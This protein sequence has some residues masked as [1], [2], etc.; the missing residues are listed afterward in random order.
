[1]SGLIMPL[2]Q[3]TVEP[4]AVSDLM[5]QCGISAYSDPVL[6]K[7]QNDRLSGLIVAARVAC[8]NY[9]KRAFVS[10]MFLLKLDSFSGY[11]LRYDC[12]QFPAID[13]TML[14]FQAIDT[15][16]YVDVAG[17]VQKL[18][19]DISYG[20]V[21][22]SDLYGYQ[23]ERGS[24]SVPARIL[25]VWARP[26]PPTR[27]V[28]GAVG[29][30]FRAGYGA[31]AT[32]SVGEGSDQLSV[33]GFSFLQADAPL[34]MGEIG[35]S[36]TIPGAG[37]NGSDLDTTV[38]AVTG[39]HS[40]TL[41]D[42]ASISVDGVQVWVGRHV[43]EPISMAIMFLA[44]FFYEQGGVVDQAPPRVVQTLLSPYLW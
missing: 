5:V 23:L 34:L 27:R 13:L 14:P 3:P 22:S 26:W 19:L 15:V 24:D 17:D 18:S 29:V 42:V 16:Y 37:A 35:L 7:Q 6:S 44:Q 25:P 8:E 2:S 43:P 31:P 1:M 32:A 36:I 20:N 11:D 41:A 38:A 9:V 10:R 28:P 21:S 30:S 40:V 39:P 33:S 12:P 4:V